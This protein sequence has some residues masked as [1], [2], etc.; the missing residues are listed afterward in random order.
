MR[1]ESLKKVAGNI[2]NLKGAMDATLRHKIIGYA[3]GL[4]IL[5]LGLY[6]CIEP[7]SPPEVNNDENYLVIDG[8]LN[9]DY[10][11]SFIEL[12]RSQNTNASVPP[13]IEGGATI[14]VES[15][16][17]ESYDFK[18]TSK[19]V[20]ML[21][22]Q[23]FDT[24]TRYRLN[25]KIASGKEYQSDY[26]SMVSTPP[27]DSIS[28]RVDKQINSVVISVNTHDP[29]NST[30]FY[31]WKFEDTYEYQTPYY[32]VY[33]KDNDKKEYFIRQG[34]ISKCWRT[35]RSTNIMLGSTIKLSQ[36]AILSLPLN[37]VDIATNKFYFGYSTLV[38][39][40][41]LTQDAFEYWTALAKTTQ[42]TGSLFDPL[43]SQV[44]GNF[45]NV[46]DP[47]ELVFG[48]FSAAREQ[49]KRLFIRAN[50]GSFP[51]CD[52][53][54]TVG[55]DQL[56]IIYGGSLILNLTADYD[57]LIMSSPYCADCRVQ[58][59]TTTKPPYWPL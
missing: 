24:K 14:K 6:S 45:R 58:G 42:G 25:V 8:F 39:Q 3:L 57:S 11:T 48:Y 23:H 17:G 21:D 36:D 16:S 49:S 41:G 13:I 55:F 47:K 15:E 32:S 59:G 53:P 51:R 2:R 50:L 31:R 18:E 37:I 43:P 30:R 44:T 28:Y 19:G 7:F 26:V 9:V 40:Y 1:I 22:P 27:I 38:K 34:N 35:D 54:D 12:R 46:N 20:Y 52:E 33:D 29:S 10:D 5:F 4:G 56:D